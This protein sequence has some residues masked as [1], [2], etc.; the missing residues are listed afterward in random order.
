M[1]LVI[2]FVGIVAVVGW[3]LWKESKVEKT[4]HPLDGATKNAIVEKLDVNNDGKV[5]IKDIAAA[6]EVV[7]TETKQVAKKVKAKVKEA[8]KKPNLAK[9]TTTK[10]KVNTTKSTG[11]KKPKQT[12]K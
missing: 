3:W 6:A 1:E 5:D 7:V 11:A 2:L 9:I 8:V 10:S 4:S 12:K